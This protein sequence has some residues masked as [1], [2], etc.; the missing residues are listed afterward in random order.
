MLKNIGTHAIHFI[1]NVYNKVVNTATIPPLW[2]VGRIIP[3]PKPGKPADEGPSYRPISLLS[4]TAKILESILLKPLQE[5]VNLA[6]HQHG[7]RKGRS[8]LTA[9]QEL[10]THVKTGLNKRKPVDRTVMVAIDLSRAFD[11]IDHEILIKDVIAL[12]LNG[13]IKR[14][15]SAYLRGRQTYVEFRGENP[16][17]VR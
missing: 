16:N 11:T 15:L 1:T 17:T 12:P 4:P 3:L 10:S 8:T 9:L 14:F 7:F 2:K 5:A 13:H 6:P